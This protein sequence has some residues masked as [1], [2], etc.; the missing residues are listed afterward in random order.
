MCLLH[1]GLITCVSDWCNYIFYTLSLSH[2]VTD[3]FKHEY[4]HRQVDKYTGIQIS[5]NTEMNTNTS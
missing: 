5:A 4:T 1:A 2:V 3:W